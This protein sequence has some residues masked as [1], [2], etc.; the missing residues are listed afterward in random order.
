ME[1]S[2]FKLRQYVEMSN[3]MSRSK[4][5]CVCQTAE[6][7]QFVSLNPDTIAYSGYR[8]DLNPDCALLRIRHCVEK[9]AHVDLTSYTFQEVI[10][11]KYCPM[12]GRN[13]LK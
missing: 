7:Q 5:T 9:P 1:Q 4:T 3:I 13:L 8:I 11:I 12:C 2:D 6:P 10:N